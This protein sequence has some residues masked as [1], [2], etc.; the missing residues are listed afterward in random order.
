MDFL[1]NPQ[2]ES[3][4]PAKGERLIE[5]DWC[6]VTRKDHD[7][8]VRELTDGKLASPASQTMPARKRG[9]QWFSHDLTARQTIVPNGTSKKADI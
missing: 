1:R 7:I 9:D 3:G 8:L 2:T 5:Q 6:N 4:P